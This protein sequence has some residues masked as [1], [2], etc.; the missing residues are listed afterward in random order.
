M[1]KERS[2]AVSAHVVEHV[3]QE[4]LNVL[5]VQRVPAKVRKIPLKVRMWQL[6]PQ[7]ISFVK[8]END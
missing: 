7:Q 3:E 4:T 1:V 2:V 8:K 6:F 5:D